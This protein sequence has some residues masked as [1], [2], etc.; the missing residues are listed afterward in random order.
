MKLGPN[1]PAAFD[2]PQILSPLHPSTNINDFK[3]YSDSNCNP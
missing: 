3:V 1:E 2:I